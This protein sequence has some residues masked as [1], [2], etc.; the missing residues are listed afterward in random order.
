[1]ERREFVSLWRAGRVGKVRSTG[2]IPVRCMFCACMTAPLQSHTH[3]GTY[4]C[5][6][7]G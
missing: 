4:V 3:R 7:R 6:C 5:M 1:M 2:D